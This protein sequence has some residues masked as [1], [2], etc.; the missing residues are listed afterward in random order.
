MVYFL[1]LSIEI[2]GKAEAHILHYGW[3]AYLTY[4]NNQVN[5]IIHQTKRMDTVL[6]TLNTFLQ[7]ET[8]A[9]SICIRK[10]GV[11]ASFTMKH[12]MVKRTRKMKTG[13]TSHEIFL[14]T[15]GQDIKP[16]PGF[17][18][19][20]TFPLFWDKF[21]HWWLDLFKIY[22]RL[23]SINT[24]HFLELAHAWRR[25]FELAYLTIGPI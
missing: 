4:L 12:D 16:D 10:E 21:I 9:N 3:Q 2:T 15:L 18:P 17:W 1:L 20:I 7:K 6:V 5:M 23:L 14:P 25:N 19:R 13:F 22:S 11:L 8:E 24:K